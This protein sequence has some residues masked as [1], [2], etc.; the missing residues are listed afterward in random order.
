MKQFVYEDLVVQFDYR[1]NCFVL[2]VIRVCFGD[3]FVQN[4]GMEIGWCYLG[5]QDF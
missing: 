4:Y 3:Y 1:C 5:F 2:E